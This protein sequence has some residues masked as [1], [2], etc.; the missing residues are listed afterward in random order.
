M[1]A[2]VACVLVDETEDPAS[3]AVHVMVEEPGALPFKAAVVDPDGRQISAPALGTG[4]PC[5]A[6]VVNTCSSNIEPQALLTVQ[7]K[8]YTVLAASPC[9][10]AL[11]VLALGKKLTPAD[12]VAVQVPVSVELGVLAVKRTLPAQIV[13]SR[14][15]VAIVGTAVVTLT[16]MVSLFAGHVLPPEMLNLIT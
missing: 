6:V 5:T 7:R 2:V 10:I 3:S 8:V 14:P 4:G 15:V 9:A 12:G 13:A 11:G 1:F 16:V